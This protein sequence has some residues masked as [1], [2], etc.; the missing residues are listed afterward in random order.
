MIKVLLLVSIIALHFFRESYVVLLSVTVIDERLQQ[1][2][3]IELFI[4]LTLWGMLI[5]VRLRQYLKAHLPI[6]VTLSGR[7]MEVRLLHL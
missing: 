2:L 7:V 5:V 3:N 1:W 6:L 4:T